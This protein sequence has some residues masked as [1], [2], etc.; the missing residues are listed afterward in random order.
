MKFIWSLFV[1]K[2]LK[3]FVFKLLTYLCNKNKPRKVLKIN[4]I[5]YSNDVCKYFFEFPIVAIG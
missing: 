2:V 4:F 1:P 3:H 5:I